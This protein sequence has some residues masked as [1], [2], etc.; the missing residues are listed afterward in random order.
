MQQPIESLRGSKGP[1]DI[2]HRTLHK[3][4]F[5]F[6]KKGHTLEIPFFEIDLEAF[7]ASN[8]P[9]KLAVPPQRLI[10][11]PWQTPDGI[12][13]CSLNK[14]SGLAELHLK[15]GD[16]EVN[17]SDALADFTFLDTSLAADGRSAASAVAG[18]VVSVLTD[19]IPVWGEVSLLIG[20]ASMIPRKRVR[21][22]LEFKTDREP[23]VIDTAELV[24]ILLDAIIGGS[25]AGSTAEA[26]EKEAVYVMG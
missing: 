23:I 13:V 15:M 25:T 11:V 17:L 10:S 4:G 21:L 5:R 12:I 22:L 16:Q 26:A 6:R 8:L 24:A 1:G 7:S 14:S 20:I 18:G 3:L 2:L 9:S 19:Q